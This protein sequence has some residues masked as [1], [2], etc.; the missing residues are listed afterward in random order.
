[1][2]YPYYTYIAVAISVVLVTKLCWIC[3]HESFGVVYC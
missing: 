2:K 1:M 3:I